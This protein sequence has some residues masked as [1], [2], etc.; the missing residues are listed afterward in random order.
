MA[1]YW[2]IPA[3]FNNEVVLKLGR[4]SKHG[5]VF[6]CTMEGILLTNYNNKKM[7]A[8]AG[9]S[10]DKFRRVVFLKKT[11]STGNKQIC[12]RVDDIKF[13]NV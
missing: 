3:G 13:F 12:K 2:F 9:E 11:C 10:H 5:D 1:L 8:N 7:T 6:T 4:Q